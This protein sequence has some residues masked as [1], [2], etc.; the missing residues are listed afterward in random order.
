M[1]AY[2]N[3]FGTKDSSIKE[4]IEDKEIYLVSKLVKSDTYTISLMI[5][6]IWYKKLVLS[7]YNIINPPYNNQNFTKLDP[8]LNASQYVLCCNFRMLRN[9]IVK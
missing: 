2:M 4:D 5:M 8:K 3:D 7:I 6:K 1:A 9:F